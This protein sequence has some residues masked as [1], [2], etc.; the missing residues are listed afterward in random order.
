MSNDDATRNANAVL[1]GLMEFQQRTARYVY[2]RLY[3]DGDTSRFLVADEVGLGKTM[4]A[5]A[6]IAQAIDYLGGGSPEKP[7]N[8]VYICSN[9]GIA[10][11]NIGKLANIGETQHSF[12]PTRLT[13]LALRKDD[14][15]DKT[16]DRG[17]RFWSM[18]P[19]TSLKFNANSLGIVAERLLLLH[20]LT[21]GNSG[22]FKDHKK[23][24]AIT[25]Q[26][27]AYANWDEH[28]RYFEDE[29]KK[30]F[31]PDG[32]DK[33]I[34]DEF[35]EL[36]KAD[37]DLMK[38]YSSLLV[39][40]ESHGLGNYCR[41]KGA[42]T[43]SGKAGEHLQ[44]ANKIIPKLRR[45]L[46]LA[47]VHSLQAHLLI[48]DEFQR[49][50]HVLNGK[51]DDDDATGQ[52][53]QAFLGCNRVR[54][55]VSPKILLLSATP[56]TMYSQRPRDDKDNGIEHQEEF[57]SVYR[58][59]NDE[60]SEIVDGKVEHL[61]KLFVEHRTGLDALGR[62]Q[63]ENDRH[64]KTRD[65]EELLRRVM[66]RTERVKWDEHPMF[67][68]KPIF[69][70]VEA[71][72]ILAAKFITEIAR[73]LE[74]GNMIEYWKSIPFP[75]NFMRE[76]DLGKKLA[77]SKRNPI[78]WSEFASAKENRIVLSRR[79]LERFRPLDIPHPKMRAFLKMV[80][81]GN[82]AESLSALIEDE[83]RPKRAKGPWQ[84]LWMPPSLPYSEPHGVFEGQ[85]NITKTLVFSSWRAV[86]DAVAALCCYEAQ[87]KMFRLTKTERKE[88]PKTFHLK[89]SE[90]F[91]SERSALFVRKDKAKQE[92]ALRTRAWG[93]KNYR[94]LLLRGLAYPSLILATKI[95]PLRLALL[96]GR[97][98]SYEELRKK[99][100]AQC[101]EWVGIL[102]NLPCKA[103]AKTDPRWYWLAP[104]LL[105]QLFAN[106]VIGDIRDKANG[107]NNKQK[108][109]T[110]KNKENHVPDI[111]E[112]LSRELHR[113]VSEPPEQLGKQP[114][115]LAE[116][117]C[118]LALAGPGTCTLRALM[119][120]N[121]D[122]GQHQPEGFLDADGSFEFLK[123]DF[124]PGS[125]KLAELFQGAAQIASGFHSLFNTPEAMAILKAW[126]LPK[127]GS[128][129]KA[130]WRKTLRYGIDGNIQSLLD[131]YV[132]FLCDQF[133]PDISKI[134][135]EIHGALTLRPSQVEIRTFKNANGKCEV[136]K[137]KN[138][139]GES[140]TFKV[141]GRYAERLLDVKSDDAD[142]QTSVKMAFNSPFR[143]FVLATTSIGQEGLDFH[144]WC[145]TV[146]HWNL[147]SNPVDFEQRE[148]RVQRYKGHAVRKNIARNFTLADLAEAWQDA[149]SGDPWNTLFQMAEEEISG[150]DKD[151]MAPF[152]VFH[153]KD[154]GCSK[155]E[156][157]IFQLPLSSDESR[158]SLLKDALRLYRMT[159]GQ[160]HQEDLLDSLR[161]K[162][163][164]HDSEKIKEWV[165]SLTPDAKTEK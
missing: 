52:L 32:I 131:E 105:D 31:G 114:K 153:D 162:G 165:F 11:Q 139:K 157:R 102:K 59:L 33:R 160:P 119:R 3:E 156:R 152:W 89:R 134:S 84:L 55:D 158:L 43:L 116:V 118:D 111:G 123:R 91:Q 93:G 20:L 23:A 44:N 25:L 57:F 51:N 151:G 97:P 82:D 26:G 103:D 71:R 2:K 106:E 129:D 7:I 92:K 110:R 96:E 8:I 65:I 78:Q 1:E 76:Y 130:Y 5:K 16:E 21:D 46:A 72:D 143:P 141:S 101:E 6:L 127:K 70:P 40:M 124:F 45:H 86:P 99:T 113:F 155:V 61:K 54:D 36:M 24:V 68:E 164:S 159:F 136:E 75:V 28:T 120:I 12:H 117:F 18:T 100:K 13:L 133:G 163:I 125:E 41:T 22:L 58:F 35:L 9:A 144:P 85:G 145:H 90:F 148:G 147:P 29:L 17:V 30:K 95:D 140:Q 154:K 137:G 27:E 38:Q 107:K 112:I 80:V 63:S 53:T 135:N 81:D 128:R 49:F 14:N 39:E 56:Y 42:S 108:S 69:A 15:D 132:H 60:D 121:S 138:K 50:H 142:R 34:K 104:I 126:E 83:K 161:E 64:N 48:L 98:L 109:N 37:E 88:L 87:A 79:Q 10:A 115:D 94:S 74:A 122:T 67:F 77:D 150:T 19:G 66:C 47:S 149:G 4:V 73:K 62:E 146:V